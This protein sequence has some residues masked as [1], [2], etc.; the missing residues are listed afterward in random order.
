[1]KTY[2][3][4]G[5]KSSRMGTD[6]GLKLLNQ[7]PIISYLIQ[8]LKNIETDTKIIAHHPQYRKFN[9]PIIADFYPEKGPLGGI[10]TALK[11]AQ[12]DCL[13]I[14]VD[15]PFIHENH[16]EKLI[17]KHQKDKLTLA[18][19]ESKIHP[20]F[21]VYPFELIDKVEENIQQN[22]LRLMEFIE[23]NEYQKVE[24]EF[25]MLEKLNINTPEELKTAEKL[26]KYGN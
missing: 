21:A 19:S 3:L 22:N 6:K 5:G 2:L 15:T 1:M 8:T 26:L 12:T 16:I 10:F 25:S 20:L 14:S 13:I 4:S 24:F 18:F 7:K 23:E 11:D 9:L 17:K